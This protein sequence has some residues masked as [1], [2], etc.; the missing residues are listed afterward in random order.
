MTLDVD[1]HSSVPREEEPTTRPPRRVIAL[2]TLVAIVPLLVAWVH[3]V[4]LHWRPFWAHYFDPEL[5][6][7]DASVALLDGYVPAVFDHPGSTVVLLGSAVALT[8]GTAPTDIEA[9]RATAYTVV[10]GLHM[11]AA[12]ALI[13][14]LSRDGSVWAAAF[15]VWVFYAYPRALTYA[16]VWG[17]EALYLPLFA[18][19]AVVIAAPRLDSPTGPGWLRAG[20]VAGVTMANKIVAGPWVVGLLAVVLHAGWRDR[21]SALRR[22]ALVGCGIGHRRAYQ[23]IDLAGALVPQRRRPS[24]RY[25]PD[26]TRIAPKPARCEF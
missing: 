25:P 24:A 2:A 23:T 12:Y 3:Q 4:V 20:S 18:A 15:A 22:L 1:H 11:I 8:T 16:L 6:Y 21:R 13:R 10:L 5:T 14:L 7:F 26:S 19:L 17:P 9:F